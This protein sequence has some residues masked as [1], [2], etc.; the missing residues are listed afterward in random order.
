M[1]INFWKKICIYY[2]LKNFSFLFFPTLKIS[3]GNFLPEVILK[4]NIETF[5]YYN[6]CMMYNVHRLKS[7]HIDVKSMEY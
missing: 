4:L 7:K 6:L 1:F 2:T 3:A 5:F